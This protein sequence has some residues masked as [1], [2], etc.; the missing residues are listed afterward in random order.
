[1]P[2]SALRTAPFLALT[3]LAGCT[4][5]TEITPGTPLKEVEIRYGQPVHACPQINGG[6]R[7]IWSQQPAGQ[8]AWAVEVNAADQVQRIEAILTDTSFERL[9]IGMTSNALR[10]IFGPPAITA[11]AGLGEQRRDVWSYRYRESKA[12]N[13]L[14]HVYLDEAG[15]VE[16][17]HPGPDPLFE[18]EHWSGG[19]H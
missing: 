19:W 18:E 7:L 11:R 16:R 17:F 6:Q 15:R 10:C 14:M 8:H 13:S 2:F 1:M 12:W 3:M 9:Q 5:M 4:N